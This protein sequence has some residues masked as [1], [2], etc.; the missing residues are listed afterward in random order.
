MNRI[1]LLVALVVAGAGA[2]LLVLYKK[3]YESK[4]VGGAPVGILIAVKEIPR[5]T[6]IA[7]EHLGTRYLPEAYVEP[8]HIRVTERESVLGVRAGSQIRPN[9]TVQW[10]DLATGNAQATKLANLV[11]VGMRAVTVP[12]QGATAS[13]LVLPGDRIDILLTTAEPGAQDRTTFSFM[14]NMLVVAV[15]DSL[16]NKHEAEREQQNRAVTLT[17]TPEEAQRLTLGQEQGI[18]SAVL[19]NP[20]DVRV[21]ENQPA[22]RMKDVYRLPRASLPNLAA[23]KP[24]AD[25][26][27]TEQDRA[28]AAG[29]A[30]AQASNEAM[31][32]RLTDAA[33][34]QGGGNRRRQ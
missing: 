20:D 34:R 14:Q 30:A 21:L 24:A 22:T 25:L 23:E 17:A 29:L 3:N 31:L 27:P 15:G 5:G 32:K 13:T 16:G 11:R 9:E 33:V 2:G 26:V 10:G 12:L 7:E 6:P 19:R 8:R 28:I 1:A 4:V 18:L